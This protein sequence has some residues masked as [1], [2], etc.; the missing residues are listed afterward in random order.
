M[1]SDKD[2]IRI[3]EEVLPGRF[4]G[5][6]ADYQLVEEEAEDGRPRLLILARPSVPDFDPGELAEVFLRALG[7]DTET[8]RV[9]ALQIKEAG[10]IRIERRPP[11]AA[12]SGKVLHIWS[13]REIPRG[14]PE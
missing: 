9:M 5:G 14:G 3:L 8:R 4:G 10:F 7:S 11:L 6:P 1:T 12:S 13:G 2:I